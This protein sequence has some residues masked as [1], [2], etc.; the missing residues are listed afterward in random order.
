VAGIV[1][2][3]DSN[4][5]SKV[6]KNHTGYTPLEYRVIAVAQGRPEE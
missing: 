2:Y 3:T 4:Y 6:F 5:F 1:G